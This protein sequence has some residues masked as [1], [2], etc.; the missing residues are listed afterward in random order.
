MSN[1]VYKDA[2][3]F[4]VIVFLLGLLE[5]ILFSVFLSLRADILFGVLYGC[6]FVT[7]NFFYLAF[8]VKKSM[9]ME[10]KRATAYMS[11]SYT[12][13]MLLSAGM[14]IVAAKVEW[15]YIWAAIIPLLFQRLSVYILEFLKKY[16]KKGSEIS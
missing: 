6:T 16:E 4:S 2:A 8:S 5:F 1:N 10:K 7:L 15:L 13:R 14:I 9:D 11:S 3:K 12:V